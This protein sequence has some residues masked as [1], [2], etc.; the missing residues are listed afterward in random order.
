MNRPITNHGRR[1]KTSSIA[2]HSTGKEKRVSNKTT[3]TA[4]ALGGALGVIITWLVG[5]VAGVD[6]PATVG[7]AIA[8]VC[9]ALVG[10]VWSP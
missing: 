6:V 2:Y 1:I 10:L 5:P 3:V 7:A 9:T 4:A 8:T